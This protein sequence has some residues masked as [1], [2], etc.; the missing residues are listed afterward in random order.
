[1]NQ[2]PKTLVVR[3]ERRRRRPAISCALCRKRKLRCNRERPCSNCIRSKTETCVYENHYLGDQ[4]GP[5]PAQSQ[6]GVFFLDSQ[7]QTQTQGSS[8]NDVLK[9]G[10]SSSNPSSRNLISPL[11]PKSQDESIANVS[12][13]GTS[14]AGP[15]NCNPSQVATEPPPRSNDASPDSDFL[16]RASH[17]TGG[18]IHF[19]RENNPVDAASPSLIRSVTHKKRFF[20]QTH[21]INVFQMFKGMFVMNEIHNLETK[22]N[23]YPLLLKCK[24]L[25]KF[26]KANRTPAWPTI[27]TRELPEKEVCDKLIDC[28]LETT[29]SVY[30]I[31]HLPSFRRDYEELWE[32]GAYP[33]MAF[34]VL[35]KL[36]L[37]MGAMSYDDEFSLRPLAI[38]WVYEAQT[39]AAEPEFKARLGIQFIQTQILLLLAREHV[40]VS[41]DSVWVTAG[42]LVR[43]AMHMGLHRDPHHLPK[44]SLFATEM[45]RRLWNT[46]IEMLLRSSLTSG[47]PALI[48]LE[49]FDTEPPGNFD[50]EQLMAEGAIQKPDNE[51]TSMSIP[52]AL[53][54]T[55]SARLTV[56]RFL[57]DLNSCGTYER[58]LEL[59]AELR[60]AYKTLCQTLTRFNKSHPGQA[61]STPSPLAL[62][63]VDFIMQ[64]FISALHT[65]YL[66]PALRQTKYAVS[67]K[68]AIEAALKTWS[69]VYPSSAIMAP[70]HR[71]EED[72]SAFLVGDP[73]SRLACSGPGFFRIASL[74]ASLLISAEL[75]NQL[76]EEQGLVPLPFRADLM[77]VIHEAK[78]WC[79]RSIQVGE[80]N[81]KGYLV[82]SVILAHL[83]GLMRGLDPQELPP[84]FL[85]AAEE[86]VEKSLEI[87]EEKAGQGRGED[88]A[89]DAR[90][91]MD[92]VGIRPQSPDWDFLVSDALFAYNAGM[93][94]PMN[95]MFSENVR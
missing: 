15:S 60:S 37:A 24:S 86:A 79:L 83:E 76:R 81:V 39:W 94:E 70:R 89:V 21:W 84:L 90:E 62:R 31:L 35:V 36:V 43:R 52:I 46:I 16:A 6:V 53:R 58:T 93:V 33:D 63:I 18:A 19:H 67:R 61:A 44:R 92:L 28:Y 71:R 8:P 9:A 10:S 74:Q 75:D 42:E 20:G 77:S 2:A 17:I 82:S 48:S 11:T 7:A 95:W 59:D 45:H 50:D 41:G 22:S 73:L 65:P 78:E 49:D 30:R 34:I 56:L 23:V 54:R 29:E 5:S 40:G 25:G 51:Y 68:L 3:G 91:E 47:G 72:A 13:S 26:I 57:N 32:P 66:I 64:R 38:R 14:N 80:T 1:M 12:L 4:P 88:R 55:I 27:P 85:K 69:A 87:L